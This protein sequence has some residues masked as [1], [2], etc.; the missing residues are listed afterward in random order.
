MKI[1]ADSDFHGEP[2]HVKSIGVLS[3][4]PGSVYNGSQRDSNT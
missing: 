2:V 4:N 3:L 1:V